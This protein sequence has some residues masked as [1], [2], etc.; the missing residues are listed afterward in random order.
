MIQR[1]PADFLR[2][3]LVRDEAVRRYDGFAEDMAELGA[4]LAGVGATV[5]ARECLEFAFIAARA[6]QAEHLDPEPEGLP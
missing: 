1:T 6:S 2:D 4:E 3:R 5:M